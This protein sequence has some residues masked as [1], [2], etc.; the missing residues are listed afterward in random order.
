MALL[1]RLTASIRRHCWPRLHALENRIAELER[2][3]A[4]PSSG[5]RGEPVLEAKKRQAQA[6]DLLAQ[7]ISQAET[8]RRLGVTRQY[9]NQLVRKGL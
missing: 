7:G 3:L 9:I 8:A 4:V 2:R 6:K 5:V 1:M